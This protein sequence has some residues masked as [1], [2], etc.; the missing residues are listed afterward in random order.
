MLCAIVIPVGVQSQCASHISVCDARGHIIWFARSMVG[1][2]WHYDT[3]AAPSLWHTVFKSWKGKSV[4]HLNEE[5]GIMHG[6]E[7]LDIWFTIDND[8]LERITLL[9]NWHKT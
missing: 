6:G 8:V 4:T 5:I 9:F 3:W 7:A 2:T 1:L